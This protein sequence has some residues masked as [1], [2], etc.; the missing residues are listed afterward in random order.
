MPASETVLGVRIS[1]PDRLV[2]PDARLTKID[3]A[4]Y[5]ERIARWMTPHLR[6]R[7]LTLVRCPEGLRGGCFFMKHSK[8]WA[9]SPLRRVRIQEKTKMGEYLVADDG[10]GAVGLAQMGVLEIHTWNSDEAHLEEPNRLVMDLDPGDEVG[11]PGVV[12]AART[13]R[14]ALDALGLDSFVKTTGGRG[15]HVVAPLVPSADWSDCLAFTRALAEAIARSDPERYTTT[16]AKAG[17]AHLILIDYLRNNRTNT[18]IAAYSTRAKPHAPISVPIAWRELTASLDPASF[19]VATV[20]G[21]LARLR[22][23]PWDGYWT[24]RQKLTSSQLRAL[25]VAAEHAGT[26]RAPSARGRHHG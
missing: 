8:V 18:S 13:V 3:V 25:G 26:T 20:P 12:T 15:L 23:D 2:Y 4:R 19:T 7:P 14:R 6:G 16:F 21:R 22:K 9:P 5:Y 24:A 11:W 1:H 17:R 10:A